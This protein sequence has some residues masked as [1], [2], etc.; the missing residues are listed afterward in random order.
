MKLSKLFKKVVH[1]R[2]ILSKAKGLMFSKK[3]NDEAHVFYFEKPQK[4]SLHMYFV[5]QTI[6]V[7]TLNQ[8]GKVQELTTLKP[9]QTHKFKEKSKICIEMPENSIK[10]HKINQGQKITI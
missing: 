7:V 2:T 10:K 3:I 5:F 4:I 6:D 9:F 8:E 1:R